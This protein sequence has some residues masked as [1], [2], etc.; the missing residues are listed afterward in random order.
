MRLLGYLNDFLSKGVGRST[1]SG[2][3]E[4]TGGFAP[5]GTQ[6]GQRSEGHQSPSKR[7][8]TSASRRWRLV[9]LAPP[10]PAVSTPRPRA[11]AF[12]V[13]TT[14]VVTSSAGANDLSPRRPD[15]PE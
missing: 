12:V 7:I 13:F 2:N 3:T 4:F 10:P 11:G 8:A 15:P 9:A 1:E 5:T 6:P 14:G